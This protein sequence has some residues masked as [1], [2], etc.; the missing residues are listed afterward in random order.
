VVQS[1]AWCYRS[2]PM[3]APRVRVRRW[4]E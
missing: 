3:A 1:S 4:C 2:A